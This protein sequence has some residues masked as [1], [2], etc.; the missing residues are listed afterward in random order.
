MKI[1]AET[2]KRINE[3]KEA[4]LNTFPATDK[5]IINAVHTV[6]DNGGT[7]MAPLDDSNNIWL[8]L[9]PEAGYQ[10]VTRCGKV[11]DV[12]PDFIQSMQTGEFHTSPAKI[13][14]PAIKFAAN[15]AKRRV[16]G[17]PTFPNPD[18]N[19]RTL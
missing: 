10:V 12:T 8:K 4:R 19:E 1:D 5:H 7:E 2:R 11:F 17:L 6:L 18:L 15:H 9:D 13:S 3:Q 16:F 14:E